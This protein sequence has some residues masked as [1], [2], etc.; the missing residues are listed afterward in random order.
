MGT[1]ASAVTSDVRRGRPAERR[2]APL[3]RT[4][5]ATPPTPHPRRSRRRLGAAAALLLL[6][7]GSLGSLLAAP[8]GAQ[9]NSCA[10]HG[11]V[12]VVAVNGLIDEIEADFVVDTLASARRSDGVVAVIL[13]FDSRG[14]AVGAARLAQVAA[15]IQGSDVPVSVWIGPSGSDALG[16]AA[17]L[18]Q[19]A[20]SSGIAPGA[21]IGDVGH[22]RL[23]RA[24]FGDLFEG[25]KQAAMDRSFSGEAAVKAELVTRFSPTIGEHIVQLDGV[26]TE[27]KTEDGERRTVPLTTVRFSKLPLSTQLFHT[28]ASPS[29]AYLLLTIG[30]GLLVFE[31]FTAG[32]GIAGVVGA[33]FTVLGGY[34]LA[35]LPHAQWALALFV[36]SFV[37]FAI[38]VQTGIPRAWTIIGMAM[39]VVASLF[40]MTEFKPTWI[41]LTAGIVGI[42]V[43]MFSGMPAMVRTRFATPTIG[44]E[45]MIGEM[46]S[47]TTTVDPEGTVTVL[48]ALWRA[49]V[50]RA[51]PIQPGER[52]RVVAI[53][54]LVL[55]VEPE[56]G[57]AIDYR[58][59]RNRRRGT[60][61]A[62]TAPTDP[63]PTDTV[64]SD[65][66]SDAGSAASDPPTGA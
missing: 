55:E 28:V 35:E 32:I 66:G 27:T 30:L 9:S 62:D 37:A 64:S 34:G 15:A 40:L 41:A 20:D 33:L 29:V 12:D 22:Q 42:G 46:G 21:S 3:R 26:E 18:V 2:A 51:T 58:E 38:D 63:A 44:R 11:C 23:S 52:V 17:E 25:P 1:L 49:R 59:M 39:F 6:G 24:R 53:D 14:A 19:V 36:L 4:H 57:G 56:E 16:G 50:N 10:D 48:G 7:I 8:A 61:P 54:G 31:F 65:A 60:V 45:W 13:Q 43:A 47:A 5:G